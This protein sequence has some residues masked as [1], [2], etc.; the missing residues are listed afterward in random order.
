ME[1]S[2]QVSSNQRAKQTHYNVADDAIP[3]ATCNHPG[4][5]ASYAAYDHYHD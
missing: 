4:Q 2:E 1:K 3:A 5:P